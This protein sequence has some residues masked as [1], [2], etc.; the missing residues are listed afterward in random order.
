M[1][2]LRALNFL[3]LRAELCDL[4]LRLVVL[5]QQLLMIYFDAIFKHLN[6]LV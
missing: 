1:L 3:V 2:P 6:F 4:L 5:V